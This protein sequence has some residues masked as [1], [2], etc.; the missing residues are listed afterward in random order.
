MI[1]HL[2]LLTMVSYLGRLSMI[3]DH[4]RL[5]MVSDLGIGASR[6][7]NVNE[8]DRCNS[9]DDEIAHDVCP[10]CWWITM[11]HP[12]ITLN[13]R[14]QVIRATSHTDEPPP[15]LREDSASDKAGQK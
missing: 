2:G 8:R 3:S 5:P 7:N 15:L 14:S 6:G 4:R 1:A 10:N 13:R 11:S 12:D 9:D